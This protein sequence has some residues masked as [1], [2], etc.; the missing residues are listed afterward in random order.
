[1]GVDPMNSIL[2]SAFRFNSLALI[3]VWSTTSVGAPIF[4]GK[5]VKA[6][7]EHRAVDGGPDGLVDSGDVIVGSGVEFNDFGL[8]PID[9]FFPAL[10]D[11]DVS[12]RSILITLII[13]Q[14]FAFQ[15][16]FRIVDAQNTIQTP[17]NVFV[18]PA[19]NWVGF[20][21]DPFRLSF[22]NQAIDINLSQLSGLQGQFILLD[23]VPEPAAAG[24]LL[25]T[26]AAIIGR[27]YRFLPGA[28]TATRATTAC[29]SAATR[30]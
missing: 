12:D 7:R 23:V 20:A 25:T 11:I 5:P 8:H 10:V 16:F 30:T 15:D 6:T 27:R 1:M 9:P 19:T 14:P 24:L 21:Q 22:D 29:R 3:M 13:D 17:Q 4:E 18:N 2:K 26:L 28:L